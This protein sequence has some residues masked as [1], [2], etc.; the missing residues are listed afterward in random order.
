MIAKAERSERKPKDDGLIVSGYDLLRVEA[1][2]K[3]A[4]KRVTAMD[5]VGNAFYRLHVAN[6][7]PQSAEAGTAALQP[8][9]VLAELLEKERTE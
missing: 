9:L 5:V 6:E 3:A 1:E 7:E 4:G 2:L 8:Q